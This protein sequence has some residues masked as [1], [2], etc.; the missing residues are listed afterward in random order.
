MQSDPGRRISCKTLSLLG[1]SSLGVANSLG[2]ADLI[3]APGMFSLTACSGSVLLQIS[4]SVNRV[5]CS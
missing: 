1:G 5:L 2:L 4:K 3:M